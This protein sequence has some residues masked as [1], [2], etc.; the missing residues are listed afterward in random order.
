M[1]PFLSSTIIFTIQ[2][3][4]NVK[5]GAVVYTNQIKPNKDGEFSLQINLKDCPTGEYRIRVY[6]KRRET[7]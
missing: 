3:A 2:D 4:D 5:D 1:F 6:Q 7:D